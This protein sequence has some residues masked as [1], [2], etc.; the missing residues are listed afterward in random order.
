METSIIDEDIATAHGI[1]RLFKKLLYILL[2]TD[3][4]HVHMQ[5][6]AAPKS[7]ITNH[8]LHMF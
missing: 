3:V 1:T 7:L 6:S 2:L 8:F 4:A 5:P